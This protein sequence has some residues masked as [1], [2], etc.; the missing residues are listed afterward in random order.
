MRFSL[1]IPVYNREVLLPRL[2]ASLR[3]VKY[4]AIELIFVDNGSTDDSYAMCHDFVREE[5]IAARWQTQVLRQWQRGASAAR[6]MGLEAASGD[7]VYFF[8]S[9]DELSPEFFDDIAEVIITAEAPLDMVGVRSRLVLADGRVKVR[10][11][12]N[13]DRSEVH[14]INGM[15]STQMMVIRRQFL[16]DAGGWNTALTRWDDWELGVRL[17][18][19]Q[20]VLVWVRRPAYHRLYQHDD[21]MSGVRFTDDASALMRAIEAVEAVIDTK[22][23]RTALSGRCSLV[24]ARLLREGSQHL[25]AMFRERAERLI[26]ER[27]AL[28][29]WWLRMAYGWARRGWRGAWRLFRWGL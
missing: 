13:T 22:A 12:E 17:L 6:Q 27:S 7:W 28:S 9:D 26:A 16:R 8:D 1:I 20:P 11:Y 21:S 25:S 23:E 15:L 19:A 3:E 2:F 5:D 4:G 18:R 14:I 10:N 29:R 24:A